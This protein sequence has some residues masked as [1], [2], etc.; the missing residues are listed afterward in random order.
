MLPMFF[1]EPPPRRPDLSRQELQATFAGIPAA[2]SVETARRYR[3][4]RERVAIASYHDRPLENWQGWYYDEQRGRPEPAGPA[5]NEIAYRSLAM[6]LAGTDPERVNEVLLNGSPYSGPGTHFAP[7]PQLHRYLKRNGDYDF[8]LLGLTTLSWRHWQNPALHDNTRLHLARVLLNE[9]GSQHLPRRWLMGLVPET[10]NHLLMTESSRYLKNQLV[11]RDGLSYSSSNLPPAAYDNA[12]N[13]FNAWFIREL[14]VFLRQDFDEYNSRPYQGYSV[15]AIQ[16][17]AEFATDPAVQKSALIVMDYLSLRF[18]TQSFELRRV[19]PFRRRWGFQFEDN[20]LLRDAESARHAV[21]V[22]NFGNAFSDPNHPQPFSR[23]NMLSAAG[24]RYSVPDAITALMIDK[25]SSPYFMR[26]HHR[27]TEIITAE[28]SFMLS[29]GGH[30]QNQYH[31]PAT[32]HENGIPLA[33]TLLL[34][35]GGPLQSR[36]LRFLGRGDNDRVNNTCVFENFACGIRPTVPEHWQRELEPEG[37]W[38]TD[39]A[40]TFIELPDVYLALHRQQ[41]TKP[42]DYAPAV[43]FVEVVAHSEHASLQAF[44]QRVLALNSKP[45]NYYGLNQYQSSRGRRIEFM[46]AEPLDHGRPPSPA[47]ISLWAIRHVWDAQNQRLPLETRLNQWPLLDAWTHQSPDQ[48]QN[49]LVKADGSGQVL[50]NHPERKQSLLLSLADPEQPIRIE[51]NGPIVDLGVQARH[52]SH[53]DP[54]SLSWESNLS[55]PASLRYLSFKWAP[56]AKPRLLRLL[57]RSPGADW[58]VASVRYSGPGQSRRSEFD[59]GIG[60]ILSAVRLEAEGEKLS[61]QKPPELY[62][63]FSSD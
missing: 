63:D 4:E 1:A 52:V 35:Q 48:V 58:Q 19:V 20:L 23:Q 9:E 34:R 42:T 37:K 33:T 17:L 26:V 50:F 55:Q 25:G 40:W 3:P 49:F 18:A 8:A 13:G 51:Q 43:G 39:Q 12:A 56:G 28:A 54:H 16:N 62:Q 10:E 44:R 27:N 32:A 30:Y 15:K 57:L 41:Q 46:M 14:G 53:K 38:L 24:S 60:Q 2:D 47:E 21:L 31:L 59:L 36:M 11:A 7:M 45:V 6:L 61:L 22:G 29:A 5:K